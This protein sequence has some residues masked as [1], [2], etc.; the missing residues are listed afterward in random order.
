MSAT[1]PINTAL[2]SFGMSGLLFHAPFIATNPLFNLYAV[3]ERTKNAA[4]EKYPGIK[5]YRDLD[6]MLADGAIELVIVNTPNITHFDFTKRA[7]Q[8]GKHVIVEKPFCVTTQECK[9]LI[10]LAASK[11]LKLSVYQN[12]RYDSDFRTVKKILERNILGDLSEMEIHYD[13]FVKELSYKTH[14]ETGDTGTGGLYDLGSHL[15]D[16]ALQ[17]FGMPEEVFADIRIIRPGSKVDDYFDLILYYPTVRVKLKSSYLVREPLVGYMIHGSAGS[18][19]KP[20]TNIQELALMQGFLPTSQNWGTEPQSESGLLHTQINGI[21]VKEFVVSEKGNYADYYNDMYKAIRNNS[22]LPVEAEDG[23]K[24][25]K[26]IE[27]AFK[28]NNTRKVISINN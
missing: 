14:K 8:S 18:F 10:D 20:K 22:E 6:E 15:I 24:V 28:S 13:R 7:L 23:M 25:I 27:A 5:T 16:Q 17:L 11:K 1:Q 4:S 3:L 21:E 2:C 12:R 26:I 19:I 9:E